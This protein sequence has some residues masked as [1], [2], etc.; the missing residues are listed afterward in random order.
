MAHVSGTIF[1]L[2]NLKHIVDK[3]LLA[4]IR[5]FGIRKKTFGIKIN[6]EYRKLQY[7]FY[8]CT[9]LKQC[10]HRKINPESEYFKPNLVCNYTFLIYLATNGIPFG[11]E[12]YRKTVITI[13]ISFQFTRFRIY[14]SVCTLFQYC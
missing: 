7:F 3:Y 4:G 11:D 5:F 6:C 2:K 8:V 1:F 10:T 12:F 14:F 13:Q 9:I